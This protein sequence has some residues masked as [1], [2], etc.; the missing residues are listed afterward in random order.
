MPDY[1]AWNNSVRIVRERNAMLNWAIQRP[2]FSD[3]ANTKRSRSGGRPLKASWQM[4]LQRVD[5]L[6]GD[7][8][9]SVCY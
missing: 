2:T 1:G 9:R 6:R 8:I 5:C 7:L 4:L 3:S